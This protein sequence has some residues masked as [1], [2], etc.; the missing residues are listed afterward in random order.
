VPQG[1]VSGHCMCKETPVIQVNRV[2]DPPPKKKIS[3]KNGGLRRRRGIRGRWTKNARQVMLPQIICANQMFKFT[4]PWTQAIPSG[5]RSSL[6]AK[7]KPRGQV[8]PSRP[9]FPLGAKFAPGPNPT[10]SKFT[11]TTP[12]SYVVCLSVFK[13]GK[14]NF[15]PQ[16]ELCYLLRCNSWS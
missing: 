9:S 14:N 12:S 13:L 5:P 2:V 16:N 6:R 7:F 4:P 11:T 15:N 10:T 3:G 1:K 8:H